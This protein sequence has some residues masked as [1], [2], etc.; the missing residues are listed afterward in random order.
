MKFFK[1][2]A[3][4]QQIAKNQLSQS[5]VKAYWIGS[6]IVLYLLL[7]PSSSNPTIFEKVG[8]GIELAISLLG[9][10]QCY[11]A[12]G[13]NNGQSFSDK[14]ISIS[15]VISIRTLFFLTLPL[16]FLGGFFIAIFSYTYSLS[17]IQT[18]LIFDSYNIILSIAITLWVWDRISFHI[19]DLKSLLISVK[20][21]DK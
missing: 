2:N 7:F 4:K 21:Q 8:W 10:N 16:G 15:W 9:V 12:N 11:L 17:K 1:I 3:L 18:D 19:R 5:D 13:A 20:D 14:L 6:S